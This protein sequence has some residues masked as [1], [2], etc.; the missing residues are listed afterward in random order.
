[1][2]DQKSFSRRD[3][4]RQASVAGTLAAAGCASRGPRPTAEGRPP[5]IIFLLTDDQRW[6]TLGCMGNPIVKTPQMDRLAEQGV[7]FLNNFVTTSICAVSRAS[8]FTGLYA[9]CHGIH[10]FATSLTPE[11]HERSYPVMLRRAGYRT[12]FIGKYGV[13]RELPEERFDYFKGFPGQGKYF[14]EVGGKTEH[15]TTT[16]GDQLAE[17]LDGSRDSEP[18]CLSVSWKAPHVQDGVPPYFLNDPA[19]D[20]LFDGVTIPEFTKNDPKYYGQLPEFLKHTE[21]RVRW[22]Q[23]FATQEAYQDSVKRYY[24]L[25]YGVDVQIGRMME[26]LRA[27]AWDRDTVVILAGDNGFY[28]GERGFAGKWFMHEESIRTPLIISDPRVAATHGSRR[29]EMTLNIDVAPTILRLAGLEPPVSVNGRDLSR[30][31]AGEKPDWRRDWFYEHLFKHERIPRSE[32][33][34]SERW[35]YCRYLDSAPLYEEMYDLANDPEEV[36]NLAKDSGYANDLER[37]RGRWRVWVENLEAWSPEQ[38]WHE[39]V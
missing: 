16:M 9:R 34:R 5:N 3:F 18:F 22:E 4:L 2:L 19:H 13:G 12:G 20:H 14:N 39:P 10:D 30:L 32:G 17:F 11:Q 37:L 28:L 21:N 1:M 38:P 31:V 7:L 35:K 24:E 29:T 15:L 6:D 33:V 27:K 26:M 36:R 23:R 25:I 8:F